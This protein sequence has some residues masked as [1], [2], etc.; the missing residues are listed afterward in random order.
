MPPKK[1]PK[2]GAKGKKISRVLAGSKRSLGFHKNITKTL[3]GTEDCEIVTLVWENIMSISIA[4]ASE[5]IWALK[6][7]S[8]YQ[9]GGISTYGLGLTT[10][11][12][13]TARM[14]TQYR[15][16]IVIR[17]TCTLQAWMSNG[18]IAGGV[19]TTAPQSMP[20]RLGIVPCD[21]TNAITYY[22]GNVASMGGSQ[23][24]RATFMLPGTNKSVSSTATNGLILFG[25]DSKV[26]ADQES[27]TVN[28]SFISGSDPS[29]SATWYY[30]MGISNPSAVLS[31]TEVLCRMRIVFRVKFFDPVAAA[32]QL[33]R[34][35]CGNEASVP[36]GSTTASSMSLGAATRTE[37]KTSL[38]R[39]QTALVE[40]KG[41]DGLVKLSQ[42]QAF[43]DWSDADSEFAVFKEQCAA[44]RKAM[45]KTAAASSAVES[46]TAGLAKT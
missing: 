38:K 45:R 31:A 24:G 30:V 19:H 11:P 10:N 14:F 33:D 17:S 34:D 36:S 3:A 42:E 13:G 40:S 2:K 27:V 16:G 15:R 25:N 4:T 8:V 1:A 22:G 7:N 6:G 41:V 20:C 5:Y 28:D 43:E 44:R 39:G 37:A 29:S 35:A 32:V 18:T 12:V 26:G 21:T 46:K 9:P 23:H